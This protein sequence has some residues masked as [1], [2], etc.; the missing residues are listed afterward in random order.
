MASVPTIDL[1]FKNYFTCMLAGS[2]NS[3]KT[4][5]VFNF[6]KNLNQLYTKAPTDVYYF[7]K[8]W[9][10]LYAEN[11]HLV[12]EFIQDSASLAFLRE[13][14]E[15]TSNITVIIDDQFLDANVETAQIFTKG[16][17]HLK[18][19][20][21]FIVQNLFWKNPHAR[22]ISLNSTYMVLFRNPRDKSIISHFAKQFDPTNAK[23]I[24]KIY[25]EATADPYSYLIFDLHQATSDKYRMYSNI[26]G[27]SGK[28]PI[29]YIRPD[30]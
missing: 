23:M 3:G 10:E 9:Q 4:T 11:R 16:S 1:R 21:I 30:D 25:A 28:P 5:F 26:F 7:Y 2:S 24:K 15:T 22:T 14:A 27:E 19:N 12:T 20:V 13:K 18:V 17:H 29:M 8:E 6:L